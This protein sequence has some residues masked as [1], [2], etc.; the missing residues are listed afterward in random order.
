MEEVPIFF[1][2]AGR[3][4]PSWRYLLDFPPP[5]YVFATGNG[6]WNSL[7]LRLARADVVYHNLWRLSHVLPIN[8]IKSR[9]ERVT[10]RPPSGARLTFAINHIVCRPES[11]VVLIEWVNMF[12][13]WWMPEFRRHT[14]RIETAL[15]SPYCKKILTWCGPARK[16][17]LHNLNCVE[18]ADKIVTLPLAAPRRS[19]T[20]VPQE[21]KVRLLFV[22]S[23]HI[24][25]GFGVTR[26]GKKH[27]YDFHMKG[28]KEVLETFAK[29]RPVYPELE[30]VV[31]ASV[32][33]D[34]KRKYEG[35]PGLRIIELPIPWRE[36][37]DEFKRADIY[38]FPCHQTTPWGSILDAMSFE[39]PVI[40]TDVYANP[41][42]VQDGISGF[43]VKA[44]SR[45]PYYDPDEKFIPPMV[46]P[47]RR[48]FLEAIRQTDVHVIDDLCA[49][50]A[51]LVENQELRRKMGRAAR[52][53]VEHGRH[54][55]E[56]RNI[57]LKAILDEAIG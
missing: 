14:R 48:E 6:L 43:L 22:G 2:P 30:L 49:K 36:L 53:E 10:K 24:S 3:I 25:G 44:S 17:L 37:E 45:V 18:F 54:S 28:G 46:T 27:L 56:R 20:K 38:L 11:W 9:I 29:L 12:T 32:P 21:G 7:M 19:F 50:V 39:L 41:E 5:G 23:A 16:S 40:T 15:A 42:L 55:I 57:A 35:F 47:R 4:H 26:L 51:L 31:R 8:L 1:E 52:W 13:G 34:L 33:P